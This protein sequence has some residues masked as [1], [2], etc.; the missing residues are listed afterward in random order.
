MALGIQFDSFGNLCAPVPGLLVSLIINDE[1]G[2]EGLDITLVF[3]GQN[4]SLGFLNEG[5]LL[6]AVSL[7]WWL[8]ASST[9]L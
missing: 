7:A 1:F 3:D 6:V 8:S 4:Y 2:Q 9:D 5:Q